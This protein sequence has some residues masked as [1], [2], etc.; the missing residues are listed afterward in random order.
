MAVIN[1]FVSG[2]QITNPQ[3]KA[4]LHQRARQWKVSAYNNPRE[5]TEVPS[6]YELE[7]EVLDSSTKD[8]PADSTQSDKPANAINW[9]ETV[10]PPSTISSLTNLVKRVAISIQPQKQP[11]TTVTDDRDD[12]DPIC[13]TFADAENPMG[14]GECVFTCPAVQQCILEFF[15]EVAQNPSNYCNPVF[16]VAVSDDWNMTGDEE[17][18]GEGSSD[19]LLYMSP[20]HLELDTKKAEL[21]TMKA[22]LRVTPKGQPG[23]QA[24]REK[25]EK[26]IEKKEKEVDDLT[27][28]ILAT[29]G[30]QA[31]EG[32]E[33]R[34][35]W[36]PVGQGPKIPFAGVMVDSEL[37]KG[38]GLEETAE[39][40]LAALE[41]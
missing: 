2:V 3:L 16:K 4:F 19:Q 7:M 13:P 33:A 24:G 37:V 1:P 29:G 25:L 38:A 27:K 40:E 18:D 35:N 9:L 31:D 8:R 32:E 39:E 20:E 5:C 6:H 30:L 23:L 34:E 14:A 17:Q 26:R 22:A 41:S 15:E 21:E 12:M 10:S 36:K 28:K 11:P